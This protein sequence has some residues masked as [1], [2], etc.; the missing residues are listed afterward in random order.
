MDL[1]LIN[2]QR[3]I[4][5]KTQTN[6]KRKKQIKFQIIQFSINII[7]VYRLLNVKTVLFQTHQ[8]S[9]S[10]FFVY[11]LFNV[12]TVLFQVIQF[13]INTQFSFIWPIDRTLSSATSPGQSEPGS[14]VNEEVSSNL[15]SFLLRCGTRP[16]EWGTQWDSNSPV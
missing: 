11:T 4:Y 14:N 9:I 10:I 6:K 5:H 7:F 1:A 2:L 13:N 3:L 12:K 15:L 8:F 16:Y